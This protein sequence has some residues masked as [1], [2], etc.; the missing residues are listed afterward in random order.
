MKKIYIRNFGRTEWNL[1]SSAMHIFTESRSKKTPDELWFTEH[2]SI[3]TKGLSENNE[4]I[5]K[6]YFNIP[7]VQC[8]RGGKITYHGPGQQLIYILINFRLNKIKIRNF[9]FLIE[10]VVIK[11]LKEFSIFSYNIPKFPGVY[12]NK[13]KFCSIGLRIKNSCSLHGISCNINT[14]LDYYKYIQPC[15]NKFI[16]MIN[17]CDINPHITIDIFRKKFIKIFLSVFKY[18]AIYKSSYNFLHKIYNIF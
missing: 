15:G 7:I 10:Q 4:N 3:F 16:Q 11:T 18:Q 6:E 14:N 8:D 13:K 5:I 9:I 17:L 12:I 1:I 2:N